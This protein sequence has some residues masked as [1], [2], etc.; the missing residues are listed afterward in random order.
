MIIS[1]FSKIVD[2]AF[3]FHIGGVLKMSLV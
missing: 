3:F 1:I 2:E